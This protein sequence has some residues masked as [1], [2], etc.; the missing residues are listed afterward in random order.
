MYTSLGLSQLWYEMPKLYTVVGV[1]VDAEAVAF[2]AGQGAAN[3]VV[4][5]G[6]RGQD[7]ADEET[8]VRGRVAHHAHARVQHQVRA[9]GRHE[10]ERVGHRRAAQDPTVLAQLFRVHRHTGEW[11]TGRGKSCSENVCS[12]LS[13]RGIGLK[14]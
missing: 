6:Q 13:P 10:T 3:L 11:A 14:I 12:P 5:P 9:G 4:G 1:A 2:V 7:D 8:G